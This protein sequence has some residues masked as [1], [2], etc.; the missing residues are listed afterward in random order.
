MAVWLA[1]LLVSF[2]TQITARQI[3]FPPTSGFPN[4]AIFDNEADVTTGAAFAGLTTFANIPYVHCLS[5]ESK[6][7]EDY[8]IA[9]LGAPFDTVGFIRFSQAISRPR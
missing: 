1:L 6:R 8:D 4:Q 5:K 3:V 7:N 2:L 9:I